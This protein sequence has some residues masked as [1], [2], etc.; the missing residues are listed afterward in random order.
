MAKERHF[1]QPQGQFF[2]NKSKRRPMWSFLLN[3]SDPEILNNIL[4]YSRTNILAELDENLRENLS[5]FIE[6]Y[7]VKYYFNPT[8]Q[9]NFTLYDYYGISSNGNYN[10]S[11]NSLKSVNRRLKEACGAG[12]LP[13]KKILCQ[14][15][16]FQKSLYRKI[17]KKS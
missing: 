6:K 17:Q 13:L 10:F 12:Q 8:A 2:F 1:Q 9:F 11:T 5:N 7:L 3:L 16:R 15:S 14:T 4:S